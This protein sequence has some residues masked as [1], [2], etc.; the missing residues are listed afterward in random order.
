MRKHD[1]YV[2]SATVAL[3]FCTA[4]AVALVFLTTS[5]PSTVLSSVVSNAV[6]SASL[7][8]S[9]GLAQDAPVAFVSNP[10]GHSDC[11]PFHGA[12]VRTQA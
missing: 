9:K 8:G 6:T 7:S 3:L 12:E 2:A 1:W 10:T 11:V 5:T 4:V